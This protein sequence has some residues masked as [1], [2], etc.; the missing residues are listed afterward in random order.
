MITTRHPYRWLP[1]QHQGRLFIA[2][3]TLAVL[4]T[5]IL[6]AQGQSLRTAAAPLGIV[7]FEL[8]GSQ[9]AAQ[10]I[11]TSWGAS[12]Q[13]VA[14]V[15]LGAD[16]LYLVVY[17]LAIGLGCVLIA[18]RLVH[19]HSFLAGLGIALGWLLLLA[20]VLD[21]VENV[22]LIRVLLGAQQAYLPVLARWCALVKFLLVGL[23]L[24]YV[25]S[26]GVKLLLARRRSPQE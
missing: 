6:N 25:A 8:A 14:G 18:Q 23:G 26:G 24:V 22:A 20:G 11:L 2:L 16:F 9:T 17:P 13:V 21:A 7:S 3:A 12:G 15:S 4:L 5:V 10:R 1:E 19:K